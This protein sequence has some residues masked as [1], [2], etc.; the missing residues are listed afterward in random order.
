MGVRPPSGAEAS[1]HIPRALDVAPGHM[2]RCSRCR[3]KTSDEAKSVRF[4]VLRRVRR[5]SIAP[6]A[7]DCVKIIIVR[8]GAAT[9]GPLDVLVRPAPVATI[10]TRGT[11]V[12]TDLTPG[13][14]FA[15]E[16]DGAL[17]VVDHDD[18]ID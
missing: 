15:A 16:S 5:P 10:L 7:Y 8:H 1:L 14:R 11:V 3:T 12:I 13:V 4:Q 2:H 17:V 9:N 6:V 18:V